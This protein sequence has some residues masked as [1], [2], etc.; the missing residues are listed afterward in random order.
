M[1]VNNI[2]R[3]ENGSITDVIPYLGDENDP[4]NPIDRVNKRFRELIKARI[5]EEGAW[6]DILDNGISEEEFLDNCVEDGFF[7]YPNDDDVE[8]WLFQ[9]EAM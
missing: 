6:G 5:D 2:I 3:I 7:G 4:T 9:S 1:K 8:F